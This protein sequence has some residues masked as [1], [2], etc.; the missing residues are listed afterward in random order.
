MPVDHRK[1]V[2]HIDSGYSVLLPALLMPPPAE[3]GGRF[4]GGA[5]RPLRPAAGDEDLRERV[6][7]KRSGW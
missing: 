2:F 6:Q 4:D 5:V 7:L 3:E 1:V